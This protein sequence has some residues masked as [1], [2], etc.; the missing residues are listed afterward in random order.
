[1]QYGHNAPIT[2]TLWVKSQVTKA[3]PSTV[4]AQSPSHIHLGGRSPARSITPNVMT[5]GKAATPMKGLGKPNS[6]PCQLSITAP[7]VTIGLKLQDGV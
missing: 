6:S 7:H 5:T 1:M 2:Y 4:P 3:A